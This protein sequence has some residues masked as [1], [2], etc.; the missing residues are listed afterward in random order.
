MSEQLAG[1]AARARGGRFFPSCR[2]ALSVVALRHPGVWER[3]GWRRLARLAVFCLYVYVGV[4]VV[5]LAL[6]N[7]FLFCPTPYAEGWLPPPPELA[8]EEVNLTSADGTPLHAWWTA[9]PG[10]KPAEGALLYCHGNAGNLSGRIDSLARWRGHG[11]AVLIFDYPG[12]GRSGGRPSEAGCYAAGDAAYDWLT[13]TKQ[14][15]PQDVI[16]YGGSLGGAVATDLASRRPFRA[17]VL[18]AAFTSFPDMAQKTF[19]WLPARWLVRNRLDNLRKIA[20]VKGPVFIAHGTADELVPFSQGERLFAA[21]PEPKRFFPM[22]GQGHNHTPSPGFYTTL[23]KFL[24]ETRT[25]DL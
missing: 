7:T 12:Y 20:A 19:P 25:G 15:R 22:P 8:V 14:V 24:A 9:P 18:V 3:S 13:G 11:Y 10:W 23:G 2:S 17:L 21:A 5:L 6:E 4:L 1:S 16:L